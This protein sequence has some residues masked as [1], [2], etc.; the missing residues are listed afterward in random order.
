MQTKNIFIKTVSLAVAI[1]LIAAVGLSLVSCKSEEDGFNP[2]SMPE[3]SVQVSS[4]SSNRAPNSDS[5]GPSAQDVGYGMTNFIFR[6]TDK[7]GNDTLFRVHTDEKTVGAA[8][9]EASLI[10]GEQGDYGLYVKTV[11]GKTYDYSKDNC[12]WAFYVNDSYAS[13]GVD[14][15]EI[16]KGDEYCFKVEK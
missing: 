9:L 10:S 11:N 6:V 8:L 4:E 1:V 12:Y 14:Q 3:S 16:V 7:E 13:A 5:Y 15:T 2:V